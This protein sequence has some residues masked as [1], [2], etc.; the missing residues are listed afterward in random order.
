MAPESSIAHSHIFFILI[1]PIVRGTF[2]AGPIFPP[3]F[4]RQIQESGV[5][6]R[7]LDCVALANTHHHVGEELVWLAY[8]L[9]DFYTAGMTLAT[10]S[11]GRA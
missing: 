4:G 10:P 6:D 2:A 11:V 3:I 1:S 5:V 7:L 9:Y 8:N